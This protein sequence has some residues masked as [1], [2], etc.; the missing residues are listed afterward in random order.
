MK[1]YI[2]TAE[3]KRYNANSRGTHTDDC[4]KRALSMAFDIDYNVV[5]KELNRIMKEKRAR[6]W[7][8]ARVFEPF[9]YEHGGSDRTPPPDGEMN[10]LL[11]EFA[12]T[13]GKEGVYIVETNDKPTTPGRGNHLTCVIDG[14]IFD[15]WD[16]RNQYVA[17]YYVVSGR[18]SLELSDIQDHWSELIK[19]AH[20][21]I[22]KLVPKYQ[23]KY[24]MHDLVF[25]TFSPTIEGYT[26]TIGAEAKFHRYDD[27]QRYHFK[28]V[29]AFKPSTTLEE[30]KAYIKKITPI[31]VYDRFYAVAADLKEKEEGYNLFKESGLEKKKDLWYLDDLTKRFFKSLPGWVQPFVDHINVCRPG[32]YSDSY[33]LRIH[34]IP[35]D[36]KSGRV[37]F[38]GY[39][40]SMIKKELQR[41]KETF[42]RP[43][44]D[45]QVTEEY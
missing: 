5:G 22:Q 3:Y 35:G 25:S 19:Y 36:P 31:R 18:P 16:S 9:I 34:P 26:L 30:A 1:R 13:Y 45:Y 7:N 23:D 27:T 20:D 44:E 42:E 10:L 4:V 11:E 17:H 15:S 24:D 2:Q 14:T 37:Y 41:Y 43:G 6:F 33:E 39:D 32:Y 21:I 38:Y 28:F 8:V 40:S 29:Y 12:D